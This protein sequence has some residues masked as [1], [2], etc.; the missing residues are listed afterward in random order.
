MAIKY[1]QW[2]SGQGANVS[3]VPCLKNMVIATDSAALLWLDIACAAWLNEDMS[4][5]DW[6][7][8]CIL[9]IPNDLG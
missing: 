3:G 8:K 7:P 4:A 1:S 6:P 5:W 9:T 2:I